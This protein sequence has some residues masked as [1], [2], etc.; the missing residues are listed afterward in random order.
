MEQALNNSNDR[1]KWVKQFREFETMSTLDRR[2][3]VTLIQSVRVISKTELKINFRFED[4]Y[5]DALKMLSSCKEA[6]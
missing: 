3:V 5:K 1:L 2:A 4:E 6:V